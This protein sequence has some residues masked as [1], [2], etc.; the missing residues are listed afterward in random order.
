[1]LDSKYYEKYGG[2]SEYLKQQKVIQRMGTNPT[3]YERLQR[4][5]WL[6]QRKNPSNKILDVIGGR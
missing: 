5:R 2:V 3:D 6:N 4:Y 1:M